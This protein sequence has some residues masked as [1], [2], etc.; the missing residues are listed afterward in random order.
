[1]Q[2][3]GIYTYQESQTWVFGYFKNNNIGTEFEKGQVQ[4]AYGRMPTYQ[5]LESK[6][7]NLISKHEE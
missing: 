7:S 3:F 2:G 4:K 1:M 6:Y 5:Y